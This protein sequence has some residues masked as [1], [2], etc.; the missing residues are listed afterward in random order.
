V[1]SI[2][3]KDVLLGSILFVHLF[4]CAYIIWVF[5]PLCPPPLPQFQAGPVLPLSLILVKKRMKYNKEDKTFLLVELRI[6]IQKYS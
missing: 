1:L 2:F 3:F 4:T 5:S 6:A